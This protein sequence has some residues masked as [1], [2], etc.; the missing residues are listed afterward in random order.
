MKNGK[1]KEPGFDLISELVVST[2]LLLL[3]LSDSISE[4][5]QTY[6]NLIIHI[7]THKSLCDISSDPEKKSS[8]EFVINKKTNPGQLLPI[9]DKEDMRNSKISDSKLLL[10]LPVAYEQIYSTHP[11]AE[12][13][14]AP[15]HRRPKSCRSRPRRPRV[16]RS[17]ST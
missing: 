15:R 7:A 3:H 5:N 10:L 2:K 6:S 14:A 13:R 8:T 9:I 12:L 17:V 1:E 4:T 11:A 16:V